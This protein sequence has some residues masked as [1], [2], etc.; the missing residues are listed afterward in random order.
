M[1]RQ[2]LHTQCDALFVVVE[3]QNHNVDF[4]IHFNHLLR[5]SNAAVAHVCDV[6]QPVDTTQIHKYAVRGDVFNTTLKDLADFE[7]L[8]NEALLLLE[9]SFNQSLV[10]NNYVLEFLIDF[11]NLEF[12]LL[13]YVL[14]KI[15]DGLYVYL[16]ARQE[17]F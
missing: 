9:L 1:R 8:N 7:A 12:H 4:L 6:Y 14:I 13:T 11:D 10:R 2:L 17:S 5:V 16:R 15:P 3:V